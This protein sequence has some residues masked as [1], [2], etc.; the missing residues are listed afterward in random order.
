ELD[1]VKAN[2]YGSWGKMRRFLRSASLSLYFPQEFGR[3]D[4]YGALRYRFLSVFADE[5]GKLEVQPAALNC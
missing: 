1:K 3:G 4:S 5:F 2:T